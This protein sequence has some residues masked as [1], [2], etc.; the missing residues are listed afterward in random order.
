MRRG[1]DVFAILDR[2]GDGT[3][4]LQEHKTKPPQAKFREF[5]HDGDGGLDLKEF[6]RGDM[7]S[8][9]IGQVQRAFQIKDRDD[10]GKLS[11]AE[12][13]NWPQEALFVRID[14]SGDGRLSMEEYRNAHQGL[15]QIIRLEPVFDLI[16]RDGDGTC[17]LD[18]FLGT[19]T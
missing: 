14:S 7:R 13:R 12:N 18:E 19:L 10:D 2:D 15:A 6:S 3:L 1:T 5:D 8:A 4:T 11:F 16:D 9:S 17:S